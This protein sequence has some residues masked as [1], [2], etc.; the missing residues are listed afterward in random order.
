[1]Y[2]QNISFEHINVMVLKWSVSVS[3][4]NLKNVTL[5]YKN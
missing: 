1:M 3:I 5:D 2:D 4:N